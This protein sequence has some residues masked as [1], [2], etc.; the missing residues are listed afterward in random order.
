MIICPDEVIFAP[1][2][3]P[4]NGDWAVKSNCRAVIVLNYIF[5]KVQIRYHA[6]KFFA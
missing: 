2:L 3:R 5:Q 6:Y 4:W 1:A